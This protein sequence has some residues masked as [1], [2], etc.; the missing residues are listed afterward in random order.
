MVGSGN[1]GLA[2]LLLKVS[3]MMLLHL[4]VTLR[5]RIMPMV[6]THQMIII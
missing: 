3:M 6:M 5:R 1:P 4:V 2:H